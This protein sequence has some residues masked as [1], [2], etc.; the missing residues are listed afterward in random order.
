MA[1]GLTEATLA[2]PFA[3]GE[4]WT[5]TQRFEGGHEGI[6]WACARGTP[7][8]AMAAGTVTE[9]VSDRHLSGSHTGR[10]ANGNFVRIQTVNGDQDGFEH[11]YLHLLPGSIQVEKDQSV[12]P[13]QLLGLSGNTGNTTGPHLHVQIRERKEGDF[14]VGSPFDFEDFLS[15]S[16]RLTVREDLW[17]RGSI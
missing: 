1:H 13:Y 3:F 6:D 8:Y 17:A 2:L 7:I 16:T 10:E 5:I 9:I 15:R 11:V 4:T 14:K 12:H